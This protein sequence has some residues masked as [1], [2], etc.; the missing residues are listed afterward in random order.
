MFHRQAIAKLPS[1]SLHQLLTLTQPHQSRSAIL[2]WLGL[3]LGFAL[4]YGYLALRQAFGGEY[5]VQDDARQHVFWMQRFVDPDLLPNDLIADYFQSVAPAGY[6]ALYKLAA[7]GGIHPLVFNKVLPPVLGV[8]ITIYCF[9]LC[10]QVFPVPAAGFASTLL[11]NQPL[12]MADDLAS[13]TPRAFFYPL[14]LAFLYYLTRRSLLPCM[15]VIGLQ[16]L[17]YPQAVFL[18]VGVLVLRLLRWRRGRIRFSPDPEDVRFCV[19]GLIVGFL[20]LLPFA[21]KTSSY[22]PVITAAQARSLPEFQSGGRTPFF[23][24]SFFLYWFEGRS[25]LFADSMLTPVTLV[26]GLF[27]PVMRVFRF[28][29]PLLQQATRGLALLLQ[30]SLASLGLFFIAHAVLFKL[31]LPSRYT[32]HS[33]R[34]VLALAA[35]IALIT[36]LNTLFHWAQASSPYGKGRSFIAGVASIIIGGGLTLYPCFMESFVDGE[37]VSS[38]NAALYS[39][40]VQQPKSSLI[41]SL[42]SETDNISTFAGRSVLV[43]REHGIPYHTG[44]YNQIRQR[45][46]DLIRAQYSPDLA[47]VQDT[48]RQYDI[49]FWLVGAAAFDPQAVIQNRWLK[50]FQPEIGAAV[51]TLKQGVTPALARLQKHCSVFDAE[52]ITL[53]QAACILRQ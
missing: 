5:V 33:L 30:L 19:V 36:L 4:L 22:G 11:L 8:L 6:T 38:S 45:V 15:G 14:L 13:A 42:E 28:Q 41:A 21:L 43:S 3:S 35:A 48:I 40:L 44:Y 23:A 50:Q 10:L 16:G 29:F 51:S 32:Q 17:F 2:F 46:Q 49:D 39:F 25:G 9:Y 37:Y 47:I 7:I 20:A 26:A 1:R 24:D 27:L 34:I 12:W 53:L 31:H 18:S 52:G